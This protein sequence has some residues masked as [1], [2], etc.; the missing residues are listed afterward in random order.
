MESHDEERLMYNNEKYGNIVPG[1]NIKALD[2]ACRRMEMA[3]TL[4]FTIPGP[5]MVWQFGELGYDISLNANCR[6][7][8]KPILWSYATKANRKHLYNVWAALIHLKTT[9]STFQTT[10]FNTYF[11]DS[12]KIIRLYDNNFNAVGIGNFGVTTISASP[13]FNHTGWWYDYFSGDSMNITNGNQ[14]I[15]YKQGE[16][17]LYTDKYLPTPNL[18]AGLPTGID[19][20]TEAP[21]N[22]ELLLYPN[23]S[24]GSFNMA[25]DLNEGGKLILEVYDM[26]GKMVYT[27]NETGTPGTNFMN[28]NLNTSSHRLTPGIYFYRLNSGSSVYNGKISIIN[29]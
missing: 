24:N 8:N 16:Y 4:F 23:P 15:S 27:Q 11:T 12:I 26:N 17:H 14:S 20:V 1:Y 9:Y 7:C 5:K 25:F 28:V 3:G 18:A 29:E 13:G 10:N 21:K 6:I 22:E 2:T 19:E